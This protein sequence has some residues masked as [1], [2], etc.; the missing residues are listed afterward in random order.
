MRVFGLY[1]TPASSSGIHD[2]DASRS[3]TETMD[4][5]VPPQRKWNRGRIYAV[6]M[7]VIVWLDMFRNMS[8]VMVA[9]TSQGQ[10]KDLEV[11]DKVKD[12]IEQGLTSHQ[13]H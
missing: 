7:L 9:T 2:V 11:S 3:T 6:V 13:T 5:K 10:D 4:D 8:A 1:F 12:W